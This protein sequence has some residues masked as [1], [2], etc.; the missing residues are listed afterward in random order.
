MGQG[1]KGWYQESPNSTWGRASVYDD[2]TYVYDD[3]TYVYDDVT[4]VYDDMC[5]ASIESLRIARGV[6]RLCMMM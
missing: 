2:V 3:V 5:A 1:Q 6:E 4:Y